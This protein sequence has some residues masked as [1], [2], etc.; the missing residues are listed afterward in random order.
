MKDYQRAADAFR[1]ALELNPNFPQAHL[2][3]A[4]LLKRRLNQPQAAGEHLRLYRELREAARR[5]RPAAPVIEQDEWAEPADVPNQTPKSLPPLN[6]EVVIVSG[7]PRSGTSMLMQMLA[8]GGLP[9]LADGERQPDEDN[10]RGYF[11]YGPVKQMR[12]DAA[13]LADAKGKAVKI[14]APLLHALPPNVACRVIFIE[15]DLD[16]VLASQSQMIARRGADVNDTPARRSRLKAEYTR[17]VGRVK[18]FL[19]NRP[20]TQA[21]YVRHEDVLRDPAEAAR[22]INGFLGGGL[23]TDRMAAEVRPALRRHRA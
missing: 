3:L 11:E 22:A 23:A 10:P 15:R 14:V 20:E 6:R 4:L 12:R 13:W 21:L 9:L 8:T 18:S 19:A 1:A 2:R 16:E 7:L 17:L 5:E